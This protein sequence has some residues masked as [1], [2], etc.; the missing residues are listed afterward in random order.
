MLLT[1]TPSGVARET[2]SDK[3]Q[4]LTGTPGNVTSNANDQSSQVAQLHCG[5]RVLAGRQQLGCASVLRDANRTQHPRVATRDSLDLVT[6]SAVEQSASNQPVSQSASRQNLA[7]A[8]LP[9]Q[10]LDPAITSRFQ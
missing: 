2:V 3:W 1:S 4:G 5:G 9:V 7:L 6:D 10:R 8:P